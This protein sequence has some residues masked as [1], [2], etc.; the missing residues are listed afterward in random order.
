[1][2]NLINNLGLSIKEF[3]EIYEIPY[4]TVRQW[5]NEERKAPP[6]IKKMIKTIIEL[7][8][9][10]KQLSIFNKPKKQ[11]KYVYCFIDEKNEIPL[12]LR[13]FTNEENVLNAYPND[14]FWENRVKEEYKKCNVYKYELVNE[15]KIK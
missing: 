6:Y 15:E 3:A 13:T 1:M 10:G 4:N 11:P 7:K 8:S 12:R 2:K 5:W 14:K 9:K